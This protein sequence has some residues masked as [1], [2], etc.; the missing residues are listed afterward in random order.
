MESTPSGPGPQTPRRV[1]RRSVEAAQRLELMARNNTLGGAE[2]AS[3]TLR[4]EIERVRTALTAYLTN[5]KAQPVTAEVTSPS[6]QDP[7]LPSGAP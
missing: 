6:P 4:R 1:A 2:E 7:E 5:G 3:G